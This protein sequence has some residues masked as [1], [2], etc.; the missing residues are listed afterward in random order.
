V[1]KGLPDEEVL[2]GRHPKYQ[3]DKEYMGDPTQGVA[4]VDSCL[5][6]EGIA[7]Q[8]DMEDVADGKHMLQA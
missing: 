2:D 5:S 8:D 6:K 3:L 7:E 1:I 4:L